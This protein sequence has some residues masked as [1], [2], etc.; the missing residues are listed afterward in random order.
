MEHL[1]MQNKPKKLFNEIPA[2]SIWLDSIGEFF[3]KAHVSL[4]DP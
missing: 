4:L 1:I 3:V 2:S